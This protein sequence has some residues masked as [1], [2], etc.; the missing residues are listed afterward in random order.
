[1]TN[2]SDG[3]MGAIAKQLAFQYALG[4]WEGQEADAAA[5]TRNKTVNI[6]KAERLASDDGFVN[7]FRVQAKRLCKLKP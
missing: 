4:F 5:V 7:D 2:K 6:Q 1:M 3:L